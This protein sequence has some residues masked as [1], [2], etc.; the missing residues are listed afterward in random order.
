MIMLV[1]SLGLA[2]L[3]GGS[4]DRL[5]E[6]RLRWP[7]LVVFAV[8]VQVGFVV[9]PPAWLTRPMATAIYLTTQLFVIAFLVANRRLQGVLV[10][11]AGMLLNMAVIASNGAMPVAERSARIAGAEFLTDHRHVEHGL[12]L[13]NE[14]LNDQ[15]V[16]P[17]FSDVIPI[18]GLA[19]VMSFGDVLIAAGISVLVFS[20]ATAGTA[21]RKGALSPRPVAARGDTGGPV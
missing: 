5:L 16:M 7:A 14:V 18:P 11:A 10:V 1:S 6:L 19:Q 12:H 4:L 3:R 8:V 2:L 13:R 21:R 17:W 9:W 20:T 15:T